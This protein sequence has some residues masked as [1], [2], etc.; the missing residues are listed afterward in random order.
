MKLTVGTW[1]S[2]CCKL[3]PSET[4]FDADRYCPRLDLLFA[5][6]RKKKQ[7]VNAFF[8]ADGPA[9]LTWLYQV[10]RLRPR[11]LFIALLWF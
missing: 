11:Q 10:Q 4:L 5:L 3:T 2:L 1:R 6:D 9:A 8:E 7:D